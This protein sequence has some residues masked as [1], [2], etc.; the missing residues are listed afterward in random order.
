MINNLETGSTKRPHRD[1][2]SRFGTVEVFFN[3]S[4]LNFTRLYLDLP[5]G[6]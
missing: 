3:H 5:I 4:G 1:L 2:R 6:R